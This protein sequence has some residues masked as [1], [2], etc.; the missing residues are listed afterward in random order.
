MLGNLFKSKA[1]SETNEEEHTI[2]KISKMNLTDMR[3]YVRNSMK[4]FEVSE[5]GLQLLMDK[6]T[7]EDEHSQKYYLNADDMPSKKKKAFDLVILVANSKKITIETVESIQRF[8]EV[9]REIIEAYDKEFKEIYDSRFNDA[10][11]QAVANLD[12]I[13]KFQ[14][15]MKVLGE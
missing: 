12:E 6:L 14:T 5:I 11:N 2:E 10:L 13:T 1:K 8:L 7:L 4:D 15:K 3:S 9:Y